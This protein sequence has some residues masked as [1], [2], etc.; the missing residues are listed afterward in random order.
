MAPLLSLATLAA[1]ALLAAG[2]PHASASRPPHASAAARVADPSGAR[3][4]ELEEELARD[5]RSPR[6]IGLVAEVAAL[7]EEAPDLSRIAAILAQTADDRGAH[8]EV[9]ALARF[10]LA[11]VERARGNPQRSAAL[12]RRLGFVQAW[13][14]AGPF[15]DEGKR[16]FEAVYPP[17]KGIDLAAA[18]PGKVRDVSWRELP[19]EAVVDGFVHLGAVLRPSR[20]VV[21]YA[22]AVVDAP[23]DER[24]RLWFGASGAAKVLVNGALALAD[25]GY[26][27]ARLDQRGAEVSLRKGPNRILVKLCHQSGRFGFTLRLA[28][29]HGDGRS[30][31]PADPAAAPL[32]AG[33]A[34]APVESAVAAL[35]RRARAARGAAEAEARI[36]L[37]LALHEKQSADAQEGR[38]A[39]EAR[40]AAAARPASIEAR[41]LAARLEDTHARRRLHVEAALAAAP[42]DPRALVALADDELERGRPHAAVR[43]LDRA[44]EA[45]PGWAAPRVLRVD[46][47]GRA[48]LEARA[49]LEAAEAARLFPTVP[50]AVRAAARAAR[51]LGRDPEAAARLRTLLALRFD[52]GEARSTLSQILAES[53]DVNGAAAVSSE[54]LRLDPS[55]VQERLALGSLLA[56]NGRAEPAEAAF[57]AALRL[58]PEDA[59]AL[60]RRGRARLLAGR[61]A[62]ARADLERALELRPQSPELKELARSLEPAREPFERPYLLDAR[63]LASAAPP[64]LPDDDAIVL[65]EVKVTRVLPSGQ[66]ATF[67][68]TVVKVLTARGADAFRRQGISWAPERQEVKV[69]RA[70]V[71]RP[72]GSVVDTHDE[73]DRSASE[74]WYRLYY[75]TRAK[76]LSFPSLSPGDVLEVA[77]RIEDVAKENLLSDYFGDLTFLEEGTRK[78]R[79]DWVLLVPEARKLHASVPQGVERAERKLPGG[80]VEHRFTARDVPRIVPEP[81]MPGWSEIARY[82]HVSTYASWDDLARFYWGLVRDQLRPTEDVRRTA[83]RVAREALAAR[84]PAMG[85]PRQAPLASGSGGNDL[86][87]A[88][89]TVPASGWDA[90][91]KR[92]IVRALYGF[93]VSQTRYVGL[94]F[95]IHGYKPYRVDD[96]LRRRFGDCKDK[97]SL[98]HALLE[99]VGVDSRIVLLRM[100]RLGRIPESPASLAVFNHAILYVPDLDLWLDGTASH[101]G[102]GDLPG[103]DRGASVLVLD[104]AGPPRFGTIPD[105]RPEENR[106]E[107]EFHVAL[108]PGGAAAVTGRSRIRGAQA[109]QYRRAYL[110]EHERRAQ[111]E[112]AF[113]RTF[114]GLRVSEVKV[115]DLARLEDDVTMSFSLEAPRYAQPDSGG[116]RFTPFGSAGGYVEAYASL[117]SRRHDLVVGEP[118]QNRFSYE[119]VLPSGWK[120]AELPE[121]AAGDGADLAFEVRHRAEGGTIRVEGHVTLKTGRVPAE[122]YAAFREDAAA[123]DRAFA[124]RVRIAPAAREGGRP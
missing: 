55:D 114:P 58:A 100:K 116:L 67:S 107:T 77:F 5:R 69:E 34:P 41:L 89:F 123:L 103:D 57:A 113:N 120:A 111:L 119:F 99:S 68:Q 108:A 19:A 83:E 1:S 22:L 48:G 23:R 3:L 32:P 26:H 33:P 9:R 45:A 8:P 31:P 27:A 61:T 15:D 82:V 11:D 62:D 35:E 10:R 106:V 30:Y 122:R 39:A 56:A 14:I 54:A 98:L 85:Q 4:G 37:A 42:G 117:S 20:E 66:S 63:A 51:R 75:D 59:D 93:V 64:P 86:E 87:P 115:S 94:E 49:A 29:A 16:G 84:T 6:G 28:D 109:P 76:T 74:P 17:E 92:A 102:S 112:K 90:E 104:G 121:D 65:G 12:L 97:A 118:M 88:S 36:D 72:D 25:A 53:G 110:S 2:S 40:R 71:W 18:M 70:R 50:G 44:I 47:L 79:T 13:R 7:A 101:S 73:A 81:G 78:L 21:A 24:V 80:V 60:E 91:T 96:I 105:A 124:R 43:L 52:D 46:A 95:G 38:A